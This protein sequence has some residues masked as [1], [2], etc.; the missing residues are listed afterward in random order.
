MTALP[1][2]TGAW[3][4][5]SASV[6]G[7][8]HQTHD[9]PNQDSVHVASDSEGKILCAVVSDGAGTAA[10][11]AEG[12]QLAA[13]LI[14]AHM[15]QAAQAWQGQAA[16]LTA[17]TGAF[18]SAIEA[19]RQALPAN[20]GPLHDFHCTMVA[21]LVMPGAS[22]I[23]QIGD[24][25]ALSTRFAPADAQDDLDFFPAEECRVF[26]G[27]RGEYANETHFLTEPDWREHLR[28]TRVGDD[29]DAMLLMTD[30]AMDVTMVRGR[31]FRGFLSNLMARLVATP[32][33][34]ARNDTIDGWLADRQTY[35]LTADDKTLFVAIRREHLSLAGQPFL[36]QDTQWSQATRPVTYDSRTDALPAAAPRH[37]VP[38]PADMPR[39]SGRT[40]RLPD[41]A[42]LT[43]VAA[44]LVT[45]AVCAII[46]VTG[47]NR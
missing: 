6:R 28:V 18:A 14:P 20:G 3:Q 22:F 21:W 4:L 33:M 9:M 1:A 43:L 35:S 42:L 12:S 36:V 29:V 17:V 13:R 37:H 47:L 19:V 15:V 30:G 41:I 34:K 32:D 44:A 5:S 40:G 25:I 31:V 10:R 46:F 16:E 23:A 11:S 27:E 39:A 45:V 7:S 2:W 24:S 8:G 26:E 38:F